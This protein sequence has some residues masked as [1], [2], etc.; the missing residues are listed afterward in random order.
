MA[1]DRRGVNTMKR[2]VIIHTSL[3]SRDLLMELFG[4]LCPD[5]TVSNIIDDSLLA[6]VMAAGEVTPGVQR[7][8]DAYVRQAA[9][10]SPE[11]IFNQC[12][13]VGEAFAK[14]VVGVTCKTLRVDAPMAEEAVSLCPDGGKIAVVAT[15][16]STCGPSVRLVEEKAA[17]SG[18]SIEVKQV[19]VD[20]ALAILMQEKDRA[21]HDELVTAA[22][23]EACSWAD[24]IVLAQGSMY[25]IGNAIGKD[26]PKPV[27]TSPY[28]AVKRAAELL[29]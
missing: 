16:A 10:L 23:R 4:K 2:A 26:M 20:G 29:K 24:V 19:L 6:E 17:E 15:V 11:L 7:R 27:L 3:V 1:G 28:L 5:V 18:K 14:A 9:S 22:V 8:M 12:S 25:E 21:K 13:S